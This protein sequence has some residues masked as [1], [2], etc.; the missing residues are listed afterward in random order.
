MTA[1][2]HFLLA[3]PDGR[4][5]DC[6]RH[7]MASAGYLVVVAVGLVFVVDQR[8]LSLVDGAVTWTIAGV[9]AV[10][11]LAQP[12]HRVHR[13]LPRAD[14]MVRDRSDSRATVAL[15]ATVLHL[16]VG[17]P[18]RLGAVTAGATVLVPLGLLLAENKRMRPHASR[19]LVQVL[20]V[21]GSPS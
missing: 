14:G 18:G 13:L 3:L 17:W 9:L 1:I 6:V 7:V 10:A 16:L 12:L 5:H 19:G 2:V 20:A 4:L 15:V 11:P 21:F 8:P